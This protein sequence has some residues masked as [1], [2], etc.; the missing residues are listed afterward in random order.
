MS[1][2]YQP[3][4]PDAVGHAVRAL[5]AV[6]ARSTCPTAPGRRRHHAAPLWCAVDLRDGNQALIDP[7]DAG[8]KRRMF[9]LLV[10]MGYK[11]IEV[12]FPSASQTDFDFVRRD[13]R[14]GPDPRRRDDPGADPGPRGADRAHRSSRIAGA[15]R[16]I[17]HLYNST[18]TLQRRV[19]FGL[20]KDGITRHRR[21]TPRG[22]A[23]SC[24]ETCRRHR[25]RFEYSPESYTGTELD[26]ALEVCDAVIDVWQPT[27]G[28]ADDRQPAGD[29][30]D[31]DPQRV[32]RLDRV[33]VA[34]T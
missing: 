4:V 11:E 25:V 32:R 13:H 26:F 14:A 23:R 24:A 18:S 33:D 16:A 6:H 1:F 9:E 28:P 8:R 10:P 34:A 21:P 31:G 29:G 12:G 7:M 17:V 27:P 2:D 20:D 5:P 22:S 30:R 19:V 15:P 3:P